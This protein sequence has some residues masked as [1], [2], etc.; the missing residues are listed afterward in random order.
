MQISV[1]GTSEYSIPPERGTAQMR[2]TAEDVDAARAS[3]R[4]QSAVARI[5]AEVRRLAAGDDAP[6]TWFSVGPLTTSSWQ[7]TNPQG[8]PGPRR[9]SASARIQVK[10]RDFTE[11]AAAVTRWGA[12][13]DVNVGYVE[14]ALTDATRLEVE[15]KAL[16]DAV[17]DARQRATAIATAC[18]YATIR[19]EQVADP[20]LLGENG[21]MPAVAYDGPAGVMMRGKAVAETTELSPEDVRGSAK[22]HAR[23]RAEH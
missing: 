10:F 11:L 22:V 21:P 19:V 6:V 16:T 9:Y 8:K 12:D 18:G 15:A 4:A 17:A 23:F 7:P 13:E 2:V 5:D 3:R 14:W 20:G 1:M